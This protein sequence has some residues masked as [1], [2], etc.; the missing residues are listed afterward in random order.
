M[1]PY[2]DR[3][4]RALQAEVRRFGR[5]SIVPVARELDAAARF[6]WDNVK[7][8]AE[9]GWFGVP[10]PRSLGGMGLDY[11]S[12]TLVVEELARHDASHA[13][14]V[15]AHTTLAISP[16]VAFGTEGQKE[17]FVPPL[18]SGQVLGG[19]G[20]TEPDAGSD[21]SGT[22]TRGVRTPDGYRITGS[23]IFIT[24]GGVGEIF[25]V[26]AATDP[27]AGPRGI[28]SFILCK[29]TVDLDEAARVGVGHRPDLPFAAGVTCGAKEEKLGWRASDTRALH[30]DDARVGEDQ[31]LGLEG[32]GFRNFMTTLNAGRIGIAALSLGIAQGALDVALR[33]AA[34]RRWFRRPLLDR[35]DVP[36]SL[37]TLAAQVAA[38]RLLTR[39]AAWLKDRGRPYAKEAA[40]AKLTASELAARS[41]RAAA[42]AM[43]PEG[44]TTEHPVERMMRD[45]KA[46]EIGEG[47]SEIQKTVIARRLAEE[48]ES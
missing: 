45:A 35:Q 15:S 22:R 13:I 8:M 32:E 28:S 24:H 43:G 16:I 4:Q 36:F 5:E 19:F 42:R 30:F 26:A 6:P 11:A 40:M 38:A 1:D 46:C 7:A 31:R 12:Y 29:P 2:L 44:C 39:Q 10:A 14:T 3:D 23:K 48:W 37:A 9:R 27:D 33:H 25:V 47:T 34:R 18:A 17:R 20:L 21:A 41:A